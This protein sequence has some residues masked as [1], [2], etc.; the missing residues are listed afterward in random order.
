MN[1]ADT[2]RT[3]VRPRL[4]AAGWD[5]D[6]HFFSEQTFFTDGR[7][8]VPAGKPRRLK[9][10]FTDFLLRYSRDVTLAVVEA[11]SD[12][13]PAG[14]GLQQAKEYAEI[15]GLKFA[16]GTNGRE[17][18]EYDFFTS[19]ESELDAFPTPEDL[20]FRYQQGQMRTRAYPPFAPRTSDGGTLLLDTAR[21]TS[22]AEFRRR[23]GRGEPAPGDIV[24]VRE[25]GGTGKAGIVEERQRFSLGQ[26]VMMFRPDRDK[27]EPRYLLRYWLSPLIYEEQIANRM[28]G[29]ASPHLNIG[30][31]KTFLFDFRHWRANARLCLISTDFKQR[32][33][34]YVWHKKNRGKRLR[35]RSQRSCR[36]L[37]T[38]AISSIPG[39]LHECRLKNQMRI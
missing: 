12:R 6:K 39:S 10:K 35:Q 1:E 4:E 23:T 11:K 18:V 34:S 38:V 3:L 16:Y 17:I 37:S 25:G 22:E 31:A 13:R 8:V 24:V 9:R 19:Q 28:L 33:T 21:K 2:C 27:I 29:S 7:I 26:R 5:G 14:N 32:R 20:W 15:L 30:A 36:E